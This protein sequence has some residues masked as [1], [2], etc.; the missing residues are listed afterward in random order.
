MAGHLEVDADAAF[1]TAHSVS[2]DAEELRE[3]ITGLAQEWTNVAHGWPGA[4]ASAYTPIW[5]EW[6]DGATKLVDTLAESSRNL[7]KAAV[8]YN[9]QDT[10][11]AHTVQT[12]AAEM[13]L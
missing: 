9:E 5:Q 3:E 2:N 7:A 10:H 13:G 12:M 4:A 11:S 6:H 8:L 1:N